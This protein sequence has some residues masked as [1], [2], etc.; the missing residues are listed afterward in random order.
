M[1]MFPAANSINSPVKDQSFQ[2]IYFLDGDSALKTALENNPVKIENDET[3]LQMCYYDGVL[4]NNGPLNLINVPSNVFSKFF[5]ATSLPLPTKIVCLTTAND[6]VK[7]DIESA[8]LQMIEEID[9]SRCKIKQSYEGYPHYRDGYFLDPKI[10][11]HTAIQQ[12]RVFVQHLTI[13]GLQLCYYDGEPITGGPENLIHV[14]AEVLLDYLSNCRTR[15]PTEIVCRAGATLEDMQNATAAFKELREQA[16]LNRRKVADELALQIYHQKPEFVPGEPLRVFFMA[17][18]RTQVMQYVSKNLANTF[19]K[20]G[21]QTCISMEQNDMEELDSPWHLKTQ[22]DFHPHLTVNINHQH[23]GWLNDDVFNVIWYQD[24]VMEIREE[25]PLYWRERDIILSISPEIDQYLLQCGAPSVERQFSCIDHDVFK[26]MPEIKRQDKAV[27]I[28]SSYI[29][30]AYDGPHADSIIARLKEALDTGQLIDKPLCE[31]L[32]HEY[33][34][35]IEKIWPYTANYVIRDTTVQWLC[36][37]PDIPVEVYGRYWEQDAV[38]A[39]YFKGELGHGVDVAK[40]YNEAKYALSALTIAVNSQRLAE[41]SGCGCIPVVYDT[42]E[43]ADKPHWDNECLFF[44]T[45]DELYAC[46]SKTPVGD[47]SAIADAYRYETLA[48]KLIAKIHDQL[49]R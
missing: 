28:G 47:P 8:F 4:I 2:D 17:D 20:L 22:L 41:L 26:L 25:N 6:Q 43:A 24:P 10:A 37:N 18:Y 21:H 49:T 11:Y 1:A 39:P 35:K 12:N 46:L 38:V 3:R 34:V 14:P 36:E 40:T 16:K 7:S 23:N 19:E 33:G 31:K 13:T 9:I 42:R 32:A 27:F 29:K 48:K 45:R 30:N 44:K 15:L 5:T